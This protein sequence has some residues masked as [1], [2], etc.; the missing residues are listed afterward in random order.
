[1]SIKHLMAIV[2]GVNIL[3][4]IL[5][6]FLIFSLSDKVGIFAEASSVR[7]QSYLLA[8]EL[9]QSSD[10][11]TR[12]GRTY[13]VT[14]EDK[15]EKIYMDVLDIR[16]GNK[17]RPQD[18]HK[19]YWD[20]VLNY[21][22][23]PKPDGKSVSLTDLMTALNFSE[24]EFSFLKEAQDNSNALVGLEVKAMN[25]VKGKFASPT[26]GQY[27]V[28]GDPDFKLARDLVHSAAYHRE[29]AK[30]MAPI[31]QFFTS[32][33][34][35]TGKNRDEALDAVNSLVN[36]ASA[37]LVLMVAIAVVGYVIIQRRVSARIERL[38]TRLDHIGSQSDLTQNLEDGS[39]DEIG[40]ISHHIN[41]MIE[42]FRSS[43]SQI[44]RES[45]KV[46]SISSSISEVVSSANSL[47]NVQKNETTMAATA[48]EQMTSALSEVAQNTQ[49]ADEFTQKTD[50]FAN[51]GKSVVSDTIEQIKN[52]SSEFE[53][54]SSVINELATESD[55]VGS[56]LVVI[57]NIAE[58]TNLLA[59]N[60]AIEAAR[61]GEQGRGFAVVADEV[62][63]LAQRTQESTLEIETMID[64]LQQKA[65]D[66]VLAIQNGAT[67]L[68]ETTAT[69][70]QADSSLVNIVESMRELANLTAAIAAATEQQTHVSSEISANIVNIDTSADKV[71][72]GFTHLVNSVDELKES[73][74][75]MSESV[76]VFKV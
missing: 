58:Q 10:E 5:A 14:G 11:L 15:Y 55:Q 73:S 19:I 44:N 3:L 72:D 18:Y 56:V 40:N 59:L 1:V 70:E 75:L 34:A 67:R 38:S 52:L 46:Q 20:L 76:S 54:T 36:L 41:V 27:T 49:K 74:A 60:A 71:A 12:L 45:D 7:Y 53:S 21:G 61:A 31:D 51:D 37:V 6:T 33:E 69:V 62:R 4:V 2:C 8:D 65:S 32:L 16:N 13:V 39:N 30:I 66:A 63:S 25:A 26:T 28:S 17:S 22:E 64:K 57:K 23:K 68:S 35:R 43:I 48:V 50:S 42:N 9:R 29:K 24:K 47:S